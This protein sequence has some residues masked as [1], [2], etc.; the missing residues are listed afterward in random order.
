VSG[1]L[2]GRHLL[3][4]T[5]GG[6]SGARSVGLALVRAYALE[7]G[8]DGVSIEWMSMRCSMGEDCVGDFV[9]AFTTELGAA[10]WALLCVWHGVSPVRLSG[11]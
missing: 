6:A 9:L 11:E 7:V 4:D 1:R 3:L 5:D 8:E 2:S 10:S